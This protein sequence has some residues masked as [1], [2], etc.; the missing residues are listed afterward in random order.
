M[1]S[2]EIPTSVVWKTG[3]SQLRGPIK[4]TIKPLSRAVL[5]S[6]E[7]FQRSSLMA[8][9][10]AERYK[11]L[12]QLYVWSLLFLSWELWLIG[13]EVNFCN[14]ENRSF[15]AICQSRFWTFG[16]DRLRDAFCG[17]QPDVGMLI[18][19][20]YSDKI[21]VWI[22]ELRRVTYTSWLLYLSQTW[23]NMVPC[24]ENT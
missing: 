4:G 19:Y 22:P 2:P 6:S 23:N 21:R 8:S 15:W 9:H 12:G 10:D 11:S 14:K 13:Y 20:I 5:L 7:G 3:V 1:T 18:L 17:H 24:Y 16:S